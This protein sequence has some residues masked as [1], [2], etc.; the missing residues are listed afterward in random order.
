MLARPLPKWAKF[1]P[2]APLVLYRLR[3]GRLL[4]H[5]FLVIVHRGRRTGR[6]YRT[7]VE[8]VRWDVGRHEAIVASGWG[9]R[10]SWWRN[11]K[12]AP[13]GEIWLAGERFEP[14][15]RFLDRDERVDVLRGYERKHPL[16]ARLLGPLLRISGEDENLSAAAE[17]LPMVAFRLIGSV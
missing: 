13:A 9:E 8:V 3:A 6:L 12:A 16:A 5:R 7:V 2:R 1:L 14:E 11:L 4:G 17:R 10:A 15:Q